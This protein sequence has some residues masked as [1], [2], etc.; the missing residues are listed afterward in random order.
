MLLKNTFKRY[1]FFFFAILCTGSIYSQDSSHKN[2]VHPADISKSVTT[3]TNT[4]LIVIIVGQIIVAAC[5]IWDYT[6]RRREHIEGLKK[7]SPGDVVDIEN[8]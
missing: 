4:S 2:I 5:L 7:K 8:L 3:T 1:F 6:I